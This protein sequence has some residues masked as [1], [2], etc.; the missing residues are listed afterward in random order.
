MYSGS[1]ANGPEYAIGYATSESPLGPFTKYAQNPIARQGNGV[2]GPGHHCV[3]TG[4]DGQLWMV[5]HQQNST[6]VGW[7]R[8][9]AIDPLWFDEAGVIHA[10][11]TRGP[12]QR[13]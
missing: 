3:V 12:T 2:Y 8:F 10:K 9:L 13:D 7:D 4:P 5:Y 6:K 11:T 1:G